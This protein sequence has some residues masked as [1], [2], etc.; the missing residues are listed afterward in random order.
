MAIDREVVDVLDET[1]QALTLLDLDRLQ[2]LEKR[3]AALAE[4]SVP[5]DSDQA[6][7]ILAKNRLLGVLLQNCA[8]NLDALSRLHGRN[9][10]DQ[11]A[12]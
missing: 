6:S 8:L 2:N 3:M 1:I 12:H 7:S 9:M 4:S 10:R 5:C 11:W